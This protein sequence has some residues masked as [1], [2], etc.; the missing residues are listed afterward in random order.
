MPIWNETFE[1][2]PREDLSR[3]QLERLKALIER[4]TQTSPFYQ[5]KVAE[6][7]VGADDLNSLEDIAQ[8]PFTTKR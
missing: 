3:L 4:V 8:L 5:K 6:A 7:G 1:T 2:M